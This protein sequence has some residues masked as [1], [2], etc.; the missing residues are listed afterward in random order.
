MQNE[1][2]LKIQQEY[3]TNYSLKVDIVKYIYFRSF[4]EKTGRIF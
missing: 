2:A 1:I 3:N 4:E